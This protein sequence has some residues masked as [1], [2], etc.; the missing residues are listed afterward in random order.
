MLVIFI[1]QFCSDSD[2]GPKE[3]VGASHTQESN[4]NTYRVQ[5]PSPFD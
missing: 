2:F 3:V 4:E 1:R 5:W